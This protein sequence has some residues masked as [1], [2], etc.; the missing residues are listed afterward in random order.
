MLGRNCRFLQGP[1]TDKG[2]VQRMRDAM[3]ADP[4]RAVTVKLLN[5]KVNGQPFWNALHVAP[6]RSADGQ[7]RHHMS[8][9]Q[10][11]KQS[12]PCM[13]MS[14]QSSRSST[15]TQLDVFVAAGCIAGISSA[16]CPICKLSSSPSAAHLMLAS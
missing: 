1:Q 14:S 10:A 12:G 9:A 6:I 13:S 8:I 2:E 5:Y 16:A 15:L 7:V 4:P 11:S 3:T